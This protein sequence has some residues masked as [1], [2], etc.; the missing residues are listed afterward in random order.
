MICLA[1]VRRQFA[2]QGVALHMWHPSEQP[3][4]NGSPLH[5]AAWL[6]QRIASS[7]LWT[8]TKECVGGHGAE[9][10]TRGPVPAVAAPLCMDRGR[11]TVHNRWCA[12]HS[13]V[14]TMRKSKSESTDGLVPSHFAST[15]CVKVAYPPVQPN[16]SQRTPKDTH[17]HRCTDSHLRA[18]THLAGGAGLCLITGAQWPCMG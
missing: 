7:P 1:G 12:M 6:V 16:Q 3:V 11:K 18:I 14:A 8:H 15:L 5:C 4:C 17:T 2:M 9:A 13:M 10:W